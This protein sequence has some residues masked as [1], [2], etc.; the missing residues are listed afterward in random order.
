MARACE[1]AGFRYRPEN[2]QLPE[3]DRHSFS[4]HGKNCAITALVRELWSCTAALPSFW[5]AIGYQPN[6]KPATVSKRNRRSMANAHTTFEGTIL[7][8]IQ[9]HVYFEAGD[10]VM[11]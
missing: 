11:V 7:S 6:G 4:L 2:F 10:G 8:E 1:T 5:N 3:V 9:S